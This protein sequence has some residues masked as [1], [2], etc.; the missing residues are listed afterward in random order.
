MGGHRAGLPRRASG[1]HLDGVAGLRSGPALGAA[2]RHARSADGAYCYAATV[3]AIQE[4]T[5]TPV[6]QTEP[7][8][9]AC[10]NWIEQGFRGLKTVGWKWHKTRR[11]DPVRV[12][13]HWLVLAIAT[14]LAVAY[15]TRREEAEARHLAPGRLRRPPAELGPA[16]QDALPPR[17]H[18]RRRGY[19]WACVWLRPTPG[20]DFST[21]LR[22]ADPGGT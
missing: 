21:R 18:L 3:F 17:R 13:R 1:R 10:R 11:R 9:Y 7:T 16:P 6:A 8:L 5:D 19:L 15:G 4:R 14:W 22:Q 12:G 2:D 20:P